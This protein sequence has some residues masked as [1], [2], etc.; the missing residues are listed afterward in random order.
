MSIEPVSAL[1]KKIKIQ[2]RGFRGLGQNYKIPACSRVTALCEAHVCAYPYH[3]FGRRNGRIRTNFQ[4]G[5]KCHRPDKIAILG[6]GLQNSWFLEKSSN[7]GTRRIDKPTPDSDHP[8][9]SERTETHK[10]LRL[11]RLH[12]VM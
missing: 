3:F 10:G 8:R 1:K 12:T 2:Q 6:S 11:A 9:V 7:I 4:N 5:Q